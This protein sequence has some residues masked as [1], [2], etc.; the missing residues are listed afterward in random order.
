MEN[1]GGLLIQTQSGHPGVMVDHS[2]PTLS[3]TCSWGTLGQ[4]LFGSIDEGQ[5]LQELSWLCKS[6]WL[7]V[8]PKFWRGNRELGRRKEVQQN[9]STC[10]LHGRLRRPGQGH[11]ER[12]GDSS[13]AR[14]HPFMHCA[15]RCMRLQCWTEDAR[16]KR[17]SHQ[18]C[19]TPPCACLPAG[20][21]GYARLAS[22]V[23]LWAAS[24]CCSMIPAPLGYGF[25]RLHM[26]RPD[27]SSDISHSR[28]KALTLL[29]VP[30]PL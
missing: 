29:S 10:A 27:W 24:R 22:S 15:F 17:S 21:S 25:R 5:D 7:L 19:H 3:S 1:G 12:T 11:T 8:L 18:L 13:C 30:F 6:I 4:G 26:P 2:P 20:G 23:T 16:G 14:Y 28:G 9:G